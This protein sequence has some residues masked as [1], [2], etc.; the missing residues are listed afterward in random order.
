MQRKIHI[1]GV[2]MD[3]GQNRRG[4]DTGPSAVRY[5]HLEAR[6]ERLGHVI[7]DEG[8]VAAP[9]PEEHVVEGSGR[10]LRAVSAICSTLYDK[11]CP[12][13]D[14]GDF[15][16]F[17]GGDHSISIG[18]VAAAARNGPIGVIWIDAHSDFNTPES[19]PS[20]NIHGMP[21]AALVGEGP[22]SLVNV[23]APGAKLNSAQIVQI[24][25]R[26]LDAAERERLVHS[27]IHV[28]TMR[29][30]DELGMAVVARQALERLRHLPRLHVSLDMDS[31]DPAEAPGVGTPVPGGLTYREAHLLMEILGDSGRV[32]SLDIVEINPILDE[33]NK[34]AELAVEL[35]ASLLGQR[36]L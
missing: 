11:A 22:E 17:L 28:F 33:M 7:I 16:L 21:V 1:L 3:L 4:V 2:P 30:V 19:S 10:R 9:N 29:H 18:S 35:A 25:I 13:L 26:D 31:L 24:G 8:N 15:A 23:G 5:A 6:L 27:G 34:T 20:G 32:G 36:I 14:A 12:W